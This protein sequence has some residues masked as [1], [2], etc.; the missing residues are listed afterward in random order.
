MVELYPTA[1]EI[2]YN[3]D[4]GN[5]GRAEQRVATTCGIQNQ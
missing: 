4:L 3:S 1:S 5:R 2:L